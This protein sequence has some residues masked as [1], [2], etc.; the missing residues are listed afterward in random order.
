[1]P[2]FPNN[3]RPARLTSNGAGAKPVDSV[4]SLV[5]AFDEVLTFQAITALVAR[6]PRFRLLTRL[7]DAYLE[8]LRGAPVDCVAL[9][10]GR[11]PPQDLTR[12]LQHQDVVG[13]VILMEPRM[14]AQGGVR[15]PFGARHTTLPWGAP[16]G[17]VAD[18]LINAYRARPA[19]ATPG[20]GK[21][22][23]LT[24]EKE[25]A[26][27]RSLTQRERQVM[28]LI[29][30]GFAVREIA[31]SLKLAESTI[32]NHKSRL[33]RKIGAKKSVDIVRFACRVG[34]VAP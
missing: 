28:H 21:A 20:N 3:G 14:G 26:R 7:G 1:M 27:L 11:R 17:A 4:I 16:W 8:N 34:A 5:L 29:A 31:S 9:V 12:V 24:W 33:M 2:D 30:E 19:G 25:H 22:P 18:A 6:D 15:L 13:C 23:P 10:D 32:D